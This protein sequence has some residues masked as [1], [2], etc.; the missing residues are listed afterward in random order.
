MEDVPV[1]QEIPI[2]R[3]AIRKAGVLRLQPE[4]PRNPDD[5]LEEGPEHTSLEDGL[6]T[7]EEPPRRP[8]GGD[9]PYQPGAEMKERRRQAKM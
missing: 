3:V 8:F 4:L 6:R 1:T 7:P 9:S 5:D 2:V